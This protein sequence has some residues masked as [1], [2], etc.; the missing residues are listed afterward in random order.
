MGVAGLAV[1]RERGSATLGLHDPG[2]LAV[3]ALVLALQLIAWQ[4]LEGYQIADSVEF[5]ENARTLVRGEEWIDAGAIRPIG[6]AGVLTPLFVIADACGVADQRAIV[7]ASYLV[8]MA[9]GLCF[10]G[11]VA[12]LTGRAF[13]RTAGLAAALIVGANPI[14]LQYSAQAESS[15]TAGLCLALGVERFL[16]RERSARD[17]WIGAAWLSVAP[18]MAYKMLPLV[19]A[20]VLV[21]VLRDRWR[22][23]RSWLAVIAAIGLALLAQCCI[24][25]LIYGDFGVTLR[26]YLMDNAT[27]VLSSILRR[28][29]LHEWGG[30]VYDL[31]RGKDARTGLPPG[32][33]PNLGLRGL[34]PKWW[35]FENLL[36]MLVVP[37]LFC[38][39]AGLL[40][41][42]WRRDARL[43]LLFVP[44]AVYAL[45]TS[46]KGSKDFRVWV[47]MLALLA[48][49]AGLGFAACSEWVRG[50]WQRRTLGVALLGSSVA[51]GLAGFLSLDTHHYRGYWRAIEAA[52]DLGLTRS[53]RFSPG[54]SAR[55]APGATA[56]LRVGSAYNWAVYMRE[57]P[58]IELIKLPHQ[59][60]GWEGYDERRKQEDFEALAEL[61][62]FL[63]HQPML[64]ANP[65]LLAWIDEHF[66]VRNLFYEREV[67]K[68]LGPLFL[69]ERR[70]GRERAPRF[71]ERRTG[72]DPRE[73]AAQRGL[74]RPTVFA[75]PE[76]AE[77]I[78]GG[79]RLVFLGAEYQPLA[80]DGFG[81]ITYHWFT[82]TGITRDLTLVDR[83]TSF[84]ETSTWQNNHHGAW[85]AAPTSEWRAGELVSEGY[86]LVLAER[87]GDPR[88]PWRPVGG[89]YLRGERVPAWLWME[90]V[91]LEPAAEK[92][93]QRVVLTRYAPLDFARGE[94]LPQTL[95]E[96]GALLPEAQPWSADG[97]VRVGGL[98]LPVHERARVPDDGRPLPW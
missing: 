58:Q 6:F 9:L 1:E 63:V 68:E 39:G 30:I 28:V 90:I 88:A 49:L 33:V 15:I 24:D 57:E 37:V 48:P 97:L 83:L 29:G 70:T 17:E 56:R 61:D 51:L 93:G 35:Y 87:A 53:A 71:F 91:E 64:S 79:E 4:A 21:L 44:C 22:A 94:R 5:L 7:W 18:L 55:F 75:G 59:L 72:V 20:V 40:R 73:F 43:L 98:F 3:L 23:R 85:R 50:A 67:H 8:Q 82:P 25:L 95:V 19:G 46:N 41:G 62:V 47:P 42:L 26:K 38:L 60:N 36:R 81:W 10:V 2:L 76:D 92:D 74:G 11:V 12:R 31:W 14:F 13:G 52:N 65:D 96:G 66:E 86:P 78:L 34:Q 77:G 80:P 27:P 32:D 16:A 89:G 69:L 45:L 84:D 54:T